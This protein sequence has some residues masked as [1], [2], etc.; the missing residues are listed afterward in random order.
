MSTF[1]YT[2][3]DY[4]SI[5]NDLLNRASVVLPE[6]TSRDSSDFGILFVD[7]VSYM[8]DILHYYVDQAARESFL[9]NAKKR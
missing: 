7:L 3:R 5:R 2:N 8:G 9:V 6:W 4:T 1:D